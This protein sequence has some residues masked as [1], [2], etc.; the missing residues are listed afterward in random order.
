MRDN[1]NHSRPK[2]SRGHHRS[3][4]IHLYDTFATSA[5]RIILEVAARVFTPTAPHTAYFCLKRRNKPE[6]VRP[7]PS[8][9]WLGPRGF[10]LD[11]PETTEMTDYV[12]DP[13]HGWLPGLD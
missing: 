4:A 9:S 12:A 1:T 7:E 6:K 8:M 10:R 2:A 13:V 3:P 5:A 11:T